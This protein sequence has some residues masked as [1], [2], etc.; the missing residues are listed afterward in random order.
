MKR[1]NI[2]AVC[3]DFDGTLIKG[4]MQENRFIPA[5]GMTNKQFWGLVKD[6]ARKNH[7]DEVLA[8]ML[9]MLDT[10]EMAKYAKELG[11][12]NY[13]YVQATKAH[14]LRKQGEGLEFFTGVKPKTTKV[15]GWFDLITEYGAKRKV[16][17]EHYI[18]SSGLYE[19][20]KGSEIGDKFKYIFA[21]GFSYDH[22]GNAKFAARSINYTTKTQ[23]LFRINK[24]VLNHYDNEKINKFTSVEDRRIPF[25]NMIY[26]GD[27][28]TDVPTM[29]MLNSQGG[30]SIAV[31]NPED[32]ENA[33]CLVFHNRA[34]YAVEAD[35][36]KEK[37]LHR[38][39]T[40][41]IDRISNEIDTSMNLNASLPNSIP[42]PEDNR[43]NIKRCNEARQRTRRSSKPVI[44][45]DQQ[46][47][48][49][50]NQQ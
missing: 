43:E 37:Q 17:I 40:G 27:G 8:Y 20:I 13:K 39:V 11:L 4:N 33:Q 34:H 15:K 35:Y 49:P 28:A 50:A 26:I 1:P 44:P 18:I 21:S 46:K 29:K 7:M 30:Y 42:N 5:V 24:G 14:E 41:L 47:F 6:R 9:L 16:T 22:L 23:Y 36:S 3:Y 48:S 38:I 19:M 25:P 2:I 32:D 12:F 45:S 10:A 31:Y